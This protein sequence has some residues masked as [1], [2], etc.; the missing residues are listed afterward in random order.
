[1]RRFGF[2]VAAL[3]ACAALT[4]CVGC[5]GGNSGSRSGIVKT[6]GVLLYNGAPVDGATIEMRPV[7]DTPNAVAVGMTDENGKFELTTDRPGDGAFPGKYRTVVKKQVQTVDGRTLEEAMAEDG[8][9]A[10]W[11]K[12]AAV[13][14]NFLPEKY[15]DP[16]N[17]PLIVEIPKGGSKNLEIVLED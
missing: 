10:D 17:S 14:E 1:M 16:L 4:V 7:D 2:S 8:P 11:D 5:G 9:E 13:T 3:L 12:D 15:L 6:S